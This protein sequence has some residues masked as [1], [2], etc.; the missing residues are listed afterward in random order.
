[1]IPF[2]RAENWGPKS[3]AFLQEVVQWRIKVSGLGKPRVS[4]IPT[5]HRSLCPSL[6]PPSHPGTW[7]LPAATKLAP[8]ATSSWA[9][10]VASV[11]MGIDSGLENQSCEKASLWIGGSQTKPTSFYWWSVGKAPQLKALTQADGKQASLQSPWLLLSVTV[12]EL[13]YRQGP[14]SSCGH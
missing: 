8:V 2:S 9:C 7:W 13:C 5:S 12:A 3:W 11:I 4:P 10:S 1:M 14:L 6:F